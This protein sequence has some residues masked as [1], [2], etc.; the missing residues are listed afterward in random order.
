MNTFNL[1]LE[2]FLL[3]L[4]AGAIPGPIL[5]AIFTEVLRRGYTKGLK[6]VFKALG[7][8][9]ITASL[10]LM[11]VFNLNIPPF[12]FYILS[13]VGA[14]Y[15]IWLGY[16]IWKITEVSNGQGEVF[17]FTKMLLLTVLNGGFWIFWLTICIPRAFALQESVS[18]G[19]YLFLLFFE[20]G[21]II[22]TASLAFV[23]S[24]FRPWLLKKNLVSAVFKT[25][26]ILLVFFALKSAVESV[27][28]LIK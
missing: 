12:Y 2:I 13:I 19:K 5:T 28:S 25:F 14:V 8:E 7:A 18:G 16:K 20:L 3:G 6:V 1:L 9:I 21:W 4:V 17:S 23:F 26:A 22:S 24:R 10:I 15:L 27:I 11:I